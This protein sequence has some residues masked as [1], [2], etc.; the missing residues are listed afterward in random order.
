MLSGWSE[1]EEKVK[2][3]TEHRI[4]M[5]VEENV[6]SGRPTKQFD[7]KGTGRVVATKRD[8]VLEKEEVER[9]AL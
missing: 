3:M 4:V 8:H 6:P 5:I 9:T 7:T 2:K 1:V